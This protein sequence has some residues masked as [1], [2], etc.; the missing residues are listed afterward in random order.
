MQVE[1]VIFIIY[2]R[3]IPLSTSNF[4]A[5]KYKILYHARFFQFHIT[6]LAYVGFLLLQWS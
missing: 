4:P 2:L 5:Q 6:I 3:K 1:I